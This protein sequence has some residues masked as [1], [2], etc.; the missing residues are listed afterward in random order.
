MGKLVKFLAPVKSRFYFLFLSFFFWS[1]VGLSLDRSRQ[2]Q[3]MRQ[4]N[5][6]ILYSD[7]ANLKRLIKNVAVLI[8]ILHSHK[9][10]MF[11]KFVLKTIFIYTPEGSNDAI[12]LDAR[13]SI[14]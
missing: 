12:A 8:I 4:H 11:R 2:V 6:T 3:S 1:F 7:S 10:I 9:L 5:T 14:R 13:L